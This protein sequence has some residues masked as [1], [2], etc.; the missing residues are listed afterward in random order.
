MFVEP[1]TE[2]NGVCYRNVLL[3]HCRLFLW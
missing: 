3:T 1:N 2:V